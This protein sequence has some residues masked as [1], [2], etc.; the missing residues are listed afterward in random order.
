ML[1]SSVTLRFPVP[2][3]LK[4]KT[5]LSLLIISLRRVTMTTPAEFKEEANRDATISPYFVSVLYGDIGNCKTSL[6][7][8][9][10]GERGLLLSSDD[11]WKVLKKPRHSDLLDKIK[12]IPLQGLDQFPYIDFEGYDTIIWDTLSQ[13]IDAFLDLL[14][15]EA[16]WGGKYRDQLKT[17][18]PALKKMKIETL[19][20]VD[21]RVTR[22]TVRPIINKLFY[23]TKANIIFTSQFTDPIPGLSA[24][25]QKRPAIPAATFKTVGTRADIIAHC[26][27]ING[28][29]TVDVTNGLTQLGKSRIEGIQG[30]LDFDTFVKKYK[31]IV[32]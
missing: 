6:A 17:T 28:K 29:A 25:Q 3:K 12:V 20:P 4:V 11:S 27:L 15:D 26:K 21:Y 8:N 23:E 19:A 1:V 7:C 31:E 5:L 18:N 30:S 16:D 14:Y 24:N 32:F 9:M 13:S 10:V 2:L 22:D